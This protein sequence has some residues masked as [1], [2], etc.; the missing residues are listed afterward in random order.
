MAESWWISNRKSGFEPFLLF[1]IH[2][3]LHPKKSNFRLISYQN[4]ILM[5]IRL[6]SYLIRVVFK[7][8]VPYSHVFIAIP[9]WISFFLHLLCCWMDV[10]PNHDLYRLSKIR[11]WII[12]I[13]FY[14]SYFIQNGV[15]FFSVWLASCSSKNRKYNKV[16]RTQKIAR[17]DFRA[18]FF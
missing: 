3:L 15:D 4:P 7:L 9:L 1:V 12:L 10:W 6:R 13:I 11:F 8:C 18:W 17:T 16:I 2:L 5:K 14:S